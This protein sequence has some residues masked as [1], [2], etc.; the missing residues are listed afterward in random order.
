VG[1]TATGLDAVDKILG[2]QQDFFPRLEVFP[3]LSG[4]EVERFVALGQRGIARQRAGDPDAAE[5]AFRAQAAVYPPNPG[6]Y[7][8][9]AMLAASRGA[10]KAALEHIRAAVVRG[11]ADLGALARSEVWS[12][13]K[14]HPKFLTLEDAVPRLRETDETWAGWGAFYTV[15]PPADAGS[16]VREHQRRR[17]AI[18]RMA[19]A[20]GPRHAGLWNRL[21]DRAAAALLEAYVAETPDAADL[22]TALERLQSLYAGGSI[23]RW[24][25]LPADAA[26]RLGRVASLSLARFPDSGQRAGALVFRA[27]VLNAER[28]PQGALGS[29]AIDGIRASLEEV[30]AHHADSP[31]AATAAEGSVRVELEAGQPGR[32]A[33]AYRTF[34]ARNAANP[35]LLASVRESLG[36][37]ALEAGGLPEFHAPALHGEALDREA[38]RGQVVVVDFWA[39]WCGQCLEELPTLRRIAERFGGDVMVVGVN[40]DHADEM[41]PEELVA[42]VAQQRVPGRQLHD[43]LGWDSELVRAFGVR[44]IPFTAVFSPAGDLLAAGARG[45][46]LERV[47]EA[48]RR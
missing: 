17:S 33:S 16:V 23:L 31:F 13:L 46:R 19:P 20:L 5:A 3:D 37:L 26:R 25:R 1:R 15:R 11:F 36:L 28:G 21:I 9:L 43:G 38:L 39:T 30:L 40:L 10:E 4:E 41:S 48:A 24:E 35:T 27:L 34:L 47:V 6:P 8:S 18:E 12:H 45:K 22:G 14:G 7:L 32:A 29:A 2:E 44:E 42:W